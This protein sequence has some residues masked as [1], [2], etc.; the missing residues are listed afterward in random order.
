MSLPTP[1]IDRIF[2]KLTMTYG[3]QFLRRWQDIDINAVKSDWAH[4]LAGFAQHP[5]AIAW[6]LQNIPADKPPTVLEF[7][8]IARKAPAE[9][10]PQLE[11]PKADPERVAAELAK[12]APLASRRVARGGGNKDWARRIVE[13]AANGIHSKS[14]LPLK[15][16]RAALAERVTFTPVADDREAA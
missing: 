14:S 4:E 11:S 6:A 13:S 16:A 8:A 15:M 3:Q 12:L 9:D 2:D 7:R 5:R 1:W 10:V